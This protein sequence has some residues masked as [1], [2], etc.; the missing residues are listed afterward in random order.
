MEQ[1]G[2]MSEEY[3]TEELVK[4][5]QYWKTLLIP[6]KR[7]AIIAKLRAADNLCEAARKASQSILGGHWGIAHDLDKAIADYEGS[8]EE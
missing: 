5:V 3:S 2:Q 8:K 6:A 4:S 1:E 7:D